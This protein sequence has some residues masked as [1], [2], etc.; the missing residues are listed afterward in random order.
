[1]STIGSFGVMLQFTYVIVPDFTQTYRLSRRWPPNDDPVHIRYPYGCCTERVPVPFGTAFIPVLLADDLLPLY[2]TVVALEFNVE[3]L[4]LSVWAGSISVSVA[5]S[6]A[7]KATDDFQLAPHFAANPA[8]FYPSCL[9]L[10]YSMA[11][12]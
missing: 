5:V 8:D 9:Q 2:P 4:S 12:T 7:L 1:M 3:G 11:F 10:L 6:E